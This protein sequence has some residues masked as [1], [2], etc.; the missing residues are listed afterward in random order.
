M[1]EESKSVFVEYFGD[2]P[3]IRVLDFLIQGHMFDYSMTEIA[4]GASVGWGTFSRIWVSLLEKKII[5]QTRVI[6][7]ARLFKL[8]LGNLAVQK[9][10]KFDWEL[11]KLATEEVTKEPKVAV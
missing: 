10:V 11:T 7:N 8:N 6:G 3:Y 1:E 9:L 2:S 5:I 4:R